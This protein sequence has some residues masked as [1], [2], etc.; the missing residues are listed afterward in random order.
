MPTDK[1]TIQSYNR[2]ALKW[3]ERIRSGENSAHVFLEKPAMYSRLPK[4]IGKS[5]LCIGC[6]S[7]EECWKM[8]KLGAG[9]V[10]GIDLSQ[11]LIDVA[12]RSYPNLNFQVMDMEK[13][14]YPGGSFDFIYS[15]LVLHYVKSWRKTLKEVYR[16]LR[17]DGVF[18]FSTHHPFLWGKEEYY[19][20]R[21][22]RDR[23]FNG[24]F[25]VSYYHRPLSEMIKD[26]LE[27]GFAISDFLEPKP[28]PA[29]FKKDPEFFKIYRN[30]PLFLIFKLE[31]RV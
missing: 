9:K 7:G 27:S 22:I 30:M 15:S 3:V 31:K 23:W 8:K 2:Y 14:K 24:E 13:L 12:K 20:S 5:V 18:L 25:K 1:R 16:V 6:G 26:I 10:V 21:K 4:M 11:K 17:K 29:C 28:V 19:R